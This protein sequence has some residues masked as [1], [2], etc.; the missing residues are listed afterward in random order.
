MKIE[1]FITIG[2]LSWLAITVPSLIAADEILFE[3]NFNDDGE[4]TRYTSEGRLVAEKPAHEALAI[5]DQEGPVYWGLNS[6][7]SLVGVPS[8]TAARRAVV[9]WHHE[10]TA[11][12]VTEDGLEMM[13]AT[14]AWLTKDKANLRVLFSPAPAGD[15][16][17][18]LVDRLVAK[19]ATITDDDVAGAVPA[20][21]SLIWSFTQ[22][23]VPILAVLRT[24][25]CR[26]SPTMGLTMTMSWSLQSVS[27]RQ[28]ISVI[29]LLPIL[30]TQPLRERRGSLASS[31][32]KLL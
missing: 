2:V 23:T 7:V 24:T 14:I 30:I 15:G 21:G 28:E 5:V 6:E 12:S 31:P 10:L 32:A 9:A 11:E 29:S 20:A 19:G 16:D 18:L 17:T 25:R 22:V 26:I 13:D 27:Q 8:L 1:R 4:G 3:E